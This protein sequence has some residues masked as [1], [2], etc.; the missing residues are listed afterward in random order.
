MGLDYE[1]RTSVPREGGEILTHK[2]LPIRTASPQPS[3]LFTTYQMSGQPLAVISDLRRFF[4]SIENQG[5]FG[6]CTAFAVLQWFAALLV[7]AGY[8][9]QEFSEMAQYDEELIQQGTPGKDVGS[10]TYMALQVV[11]QIGVMAE[12]VFDYIRQHFGVTPPDKWIPHLHLMAKQAQAIKP[13]AQHSLRDQIR[14]ALSQGHPVLAGY[15]V[16]QEIESQQVAQTGVLPM[17]TATE[18]PIGGH[19]TV[20][21]GHD[22]NYTHPSVPG[23]TGYYLMRNQWSSSW[24]Q[25]GY[26]YMPYD[27][28]D[29][30]LSEYA[31]VGFAPNVQDL[32]QPA[33]DTYGLSIAFNK[34][35]Y[36]VNESGS[37]TVTTTKND[38]PYNTGLNGVTPTV[39]IDGGPT[40][41]IPTITNGQGG[42]GGLS[43]SSPGTMTAEA[44][45]E[46][47]T[48]LTQHA[49]ASA[50][51]TN[52]PTPAPKPQPEPKPAPSPSS[53]YLEGGDVSKFQGNVSWAD[54][55]KSWSFDFA[56]AIDG[57]T[58]IDPDFVANYANAQKAGIISG[59]YQ[60][61]YPIYETAQQAYAAYKAL[62]EAH[63]GFVLPPTLDLEQAGCGS[64][65]P[66]RVTQWASEW[67]SL[68]IT[69]Y[70]R[71]IIY[72]GEAF[73]QSHIDV[74]KMPKGTL[75]WVANYSQ[76]P[77]MHW[78]FWQHTDAAT[79]K[80]IAGQVDTDYFNGTLEQ[81][82]ALCV[83]GENVIT[84]KVNVNGHEVPTVVYNNENYV[85]WTELETFPGF[86]KQYVNGEWKFTVPTQ[87]KPVSV[88]LSYADGTTQAIK[89]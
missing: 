54:V 62:I 77:S 27:Y 88:T 37:F 38:Q 65:S 12:A 21:V 80:G 83:G 3:R 18:K 47:P 10:D 66:A 89:L 19:E 46:D 68:A 45:W 53:N 58:P 73:F 26:F 23:V 16:F 34:S 29:K 63:G 59:S 48:G 33:A 25:H 11:E 17:P 36:R 14:D 24:G 42:L 6:S 76:E 69:D 70:G 8:T 78:D 15:L 81:L 1:A 75:Y 13:S 82:K 85:L 60:V 31:I 51:W 40:G 56:K 74:T 57:R 5:V 20:I 35:Q 2:F 30:Y 86:S 79:V 61:G 50:Q 4:G 28:L 67:L 39:S 41:Q 49:I 7:Q 22:D 64:Q 87:E 9:W 72:S 52:T 32:P 55:E 43:M 84:G 44:Y 71:A